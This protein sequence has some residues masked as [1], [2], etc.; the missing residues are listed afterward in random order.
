M[1]VGCFCSFF[2]VFE[3]WNNPCRAA[4]GSAWLQL[5]LLEQGRDGATGA[6]RDWGAADSCGSVLFYP[7]S[8]A[9]IELIE[10]RCWLL[11][12][13]AA[14]AP[15]RVQTQYQYRLP[16]ASAPRRI[17]TPAVQL[18]RGMYVYMHVLPARGSDP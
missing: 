18:H 16:A 5:G 13:I 14:A 10:E 4:S 11:D 17:S 1:I 2:S 6:A 7:G 8:A 15:G 12:L 3:L 9:A